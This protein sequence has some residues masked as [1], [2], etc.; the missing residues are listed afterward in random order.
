M[1]LNLEFLGM[2]LVVSLRSIVRLVEV[3]RVSC[4]VKRQLVFRAFL[5]SATFVTVLILISLL[6]EFV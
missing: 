3:V 4:P 6:V 2:S 5:D 1:I